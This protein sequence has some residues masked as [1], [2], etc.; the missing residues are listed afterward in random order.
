MEEGQQPETPLL[1]NPQSPSSPPLAL[2]SHLAFLPLPNFAAITAT[3][4]YSH[5]FLH[6]WAPVNQVAIEYRRRGHKAG[7]AWTAVLNVPIF[8]PPVSIWSDLMQ[9]SPRQQGLLSKKQANPLW[10]SQVC[11]NVVETTTQNIK[12]SR[13]SLL[14]NAWLIQ[15]SSKG[16][17][18]GEKLY[19][20]HLFDSETYGKDS[21]WRLF[22][23]LCHLP[24]DKTC[25][26]RNEPLVM[27]QGVRE[28]APRRVTT[29]SVCAF[30]TSLLPPCVCSFSAPTKLAQS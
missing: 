21:W 16:L 20:C 27:S 1:P 2:P 6:N 15:F 13:S 3:K 11:A 23:C 10:W 30:E 19:T 18:L 22:C 14:P 9:K 28:K 5:T 29:T 26:S 24:E 25:S 12:V 8:L 7:S 4:I 17:T